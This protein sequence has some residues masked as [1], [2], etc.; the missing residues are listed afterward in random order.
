MYANILV[1]IVLYFTVDL[2]KIY[3]N[4]PFFWFEKLYYYIFYTANKGNLNFYSKDKN[5]HT[6]LPSS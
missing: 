3:K 2:T 4:I 6:F 1:R 5:S